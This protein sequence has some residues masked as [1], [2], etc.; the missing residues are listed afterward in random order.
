MTNNEE[1]YNRLKDELE[2]TTNSWPTKYLYKFIVPNTEHAKQE[3]RDIFKDKKATISTKE[4]KGA[5]YTAFSI[6][7]IAISSDEIINFY[8]QAS[9]IEGIISL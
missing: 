8:K 1:F 7:L 5:K 4:S 3:L 2:K 9:T 6:D